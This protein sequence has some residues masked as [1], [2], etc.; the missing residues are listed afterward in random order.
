[1]NTFISP[2]NQKLLWQTISQSPLFSE[3]PQKEE[4]FRN[5]VGQFYES[6]KLNNM[7]SLKEINVATIKFMM[8]K[9]KENAPSSAINPYQSPHQ[10]QQSN[11]PYTKQDIS[12]LRKNDFDE[13]LRTL[14]N[15]HKTLLKK[16]LPPE[17]DF[18]DK[19]EEGPIANIGDLIKMEIEKR[20]RE[21]SEYATRVPPQAISHI[22]AKPPTSTA[23]HP[24]DEVKKSVSWSTPE[25]E[26]ERAVERA[27]EPY[28]QKINGFTED[29]V[30]LKE[31]IS[32]LKEQLSTVHTMIKIDHANKRSFSIE[33]PITV[34]DKNPMFLENVIEGSS[35]KSED[36][37][38]EETIQEPEPTPEET[39]HVVLNEKLS[40]TIPDDSVEII[41]NVPK[42]PRNRKNKKKSN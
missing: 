21:I 33:E 22:S 25:N 23:S 35:E 37:A 5:I 16:E 41:E 36:T 15:E 8:S 27:I 6:N 39:T 28:K 38:I 9:L 13:K 19:L 17:I 11:I 31:E 2:N 34:S 10:T 20:N 7:I 30:A 40:I 24:H 32:A 1:M 14:E 3:K 12:N 29:I 18:R 26:I 42:A 4:W